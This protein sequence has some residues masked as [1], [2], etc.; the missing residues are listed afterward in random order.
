MFARF[1][2]VAKVIDARTDEFISIV[3][4]ELLDDCMR[5]LR[6]SFVPS[7]RNRHTQSTISS[8]KSVA[9]V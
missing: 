5:L 1:T 3:E 8:T 4:L 9:D 6:C 2:N 7:I